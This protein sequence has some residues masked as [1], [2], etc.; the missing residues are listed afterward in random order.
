MQRNT[1]NLRCAC[2]SSAEETKKLV[3]LMAWNYSFDVGLA[4]GC[5]TNKATITPQGCH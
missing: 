1:V 2:S 5:G 4:N 3:K